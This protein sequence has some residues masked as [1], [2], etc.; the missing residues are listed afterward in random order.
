T[1]AVT[2]S[3]T[4]TYSGATSITGGSLLVT[5]ALANTAS[6]TVANGATLGGSGSI[7][8]TGTSGVVT[9]QSG[10]ILAPG[11]SP[12]LLTLNN[13]LT[14]SSGGILAMEITGTTA[15]TGYDQLKVNG[16]VD[17]TGATLSLSL[18]S[19]VPTGGDRFTLIDNDAADAIVGT[20]NGLAEGAST[21]ISN[22]S[23]LVS[24]VG[25]DG[26]DLVLTAVINNTSPVLTNLNLDSVNWAGANNSVILDASGNASV[27][28]TEN[29]AA[30]WNGASLTVQRAGTA[31]SAD[32]F[33]FSTSGASFTVSGNNL[34]TAGQTFATFTNTNGILTL[35]FANG[36][37][38]ATNAL[39]QDV[40]RHISYRNDTPSGEATLRFTLNDGAGG[41]NTADVTVASDSIYVT[42][43]VDTATVDVSNGVSFSEAVAIAAAD[44]TGT[45]TLVLPASLPSTGSTAANLLI[46]DLTLTENLSIR[47]EGS[48][49]L[50]GTHTLTIPAGIDL[51][52]SNS[53]LY[54]MNPI[55]GAGN[56]ISTI[57]G[58]PL[59][60]TSTS[61]SGFTGTIRMTAGFI[62]A[63]SASSFGGATLIATDTS[64]YYT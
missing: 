16:T 25:G 12:G 14:V 20:L 64:G 59:I 5:G 1:G 62:Q 23:F 46:A 10:G 50:G 4:S 56:I 22:K 40:I 55:A 19:F 38:D 13:G 61:N 30:N 27:S 53:G 2:L 37:T 3:G 21:T 33:G 49:R 51:S 17:I 35:S 60:F 42:N 44:T 63:E 8:T 29:D 58:S 45:Q 31:V 15:G 54:L 9:V 39:V 43:P 7:G 52:F 24:Y 57:N 34:Q 41:S 6:V 26:N 18:G 28:D 11:N 48:W 32:T 36:G 47:Q